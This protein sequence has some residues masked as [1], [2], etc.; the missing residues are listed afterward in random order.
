MANMQQ[1]RACYQFLVCM[2]TPKSSSA[3]VFFVRVSRAHAAMCNCIVLGYLKLGGA[4]LCTLLERVR[5]HNGVLCM[6]DL[7]AAAS[8]MAFRYRQ[9]GSKKPVLPAS[10]A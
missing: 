2:R 3:D 5:V 1:Q 6:A 9:Q 7:P 8:L 10:P 4:L